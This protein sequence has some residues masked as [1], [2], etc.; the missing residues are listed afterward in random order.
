MI[1]EELFIGSVFIS[2]V[3]SFDLS[4]QVKT[5]IYL[6]RLGQGYREH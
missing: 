2:D 1:D 4:D 6:E 3:V 5:E